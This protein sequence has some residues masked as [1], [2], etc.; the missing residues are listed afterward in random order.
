MLRET[1]ACGCKA[2]GRAAR[3]QHCALG[4]PFRAAALLLPILPRFVM[5]VPAVERCRG[6]V[7]PVSLQDCAGKPKLVSSSRVSWSSVEVELPNPPGLRCVFRAFPLLCHQSAGIVFKG[8]CSWKDAGKAAILGNHVSP[9]LW[10]QSRL[11][12]MM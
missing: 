7:C 11:L 2:L 5:S 12:G 6:F 1:S 3:Q 9:S 8:W 10:K 4:F